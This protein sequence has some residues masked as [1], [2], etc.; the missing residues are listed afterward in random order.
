MPLSVNDKK[1]IVC[2]IIILL[3]F[4]GGMYLFRRC[5][6]KHGEILTQQDSIIT[7]KDVRTAKEPFKFD[8]NTADYD[9]FVSLGL[10][11]NVA[12]AIINYRKAGGVFRKPEDLSKIYTL[13]DSDYLRLLPYITIHN[14]QNHRNFTQHNKQRQRYTSDTK[15]ETHPSNTYS[16]HSYKLHSGQTIDANNS[17]STLLQKVPGIGPYYANKIIRYRNRLGGFISTTQL[18]E[19]NGL[20]DNIEEWFSISKAQITKLKINH[21]TFGQLLRHPYLNYEQVVS[22]FNY[23]K[24]YGTIHSVKDL[25]TYPVFS[26]DD[27]KRLEPYLDFSE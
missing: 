24:V 26:Q 1:A 2:I 19:I 20:P 12:K 13:S 5:Q 25:S 16:Y 21:L 14:T 6:S 27:L 8:P 23:R 11:P 7:Q 22:I 17:D 18:K 10:R 4:N 15:R 3:G 9:T